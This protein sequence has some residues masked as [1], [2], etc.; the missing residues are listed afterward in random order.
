MQFASKCILLLLRIF[1]KKKNN[2][3]LRRY[4]RNKS[5]TIKHT[6][7]SKHLKC[8][9]NHKTI[10]FCTR[11]KWEK[12]TKFYYGNHQMVFL[13][14]INILHELNNGQILSRKRKIILLK[15]KRIL[16]FTVFKI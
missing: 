7:L 6:H 4:S 12:M 14:A 15:N 2:G 3:P 8:E 11:M 16:V 1:L 9:K 5:F 10:V 13:I